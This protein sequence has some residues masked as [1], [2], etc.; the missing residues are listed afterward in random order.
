MGKI[1]GNIKKDKEKEAFEFVQ[2]AK[3]KAFVDLISSN[4]DI[5]PN[6]SNR[7]S[8]KDEME[9][10]I[11]VEKE[12]LKKKKTVQ[13]QSI[14]DV[15]ELQNQRASE[16]KPGQII[17]VVE[18]LNNLYDQMEKIDPEYVSLRRPKPITLD[19]IASRLDNLFSNGTG[20]NVVIIEY[21]VTESKLYIFCVF[22]GKLYVKEIEELTKAK[23]YGYMQLYNVYI[24]DLLH[25]YC[26][27]AL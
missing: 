9:E 4:I 6:I 2:R 24:I 14:R 21:F 23:L 8:T 15:N 1:D 27:T 18:D 26:Q 5:K 13:L 19:K 11:R 12:L 25:N 22:D 16:V 20:K 3:S 7:N 17:K 10:L